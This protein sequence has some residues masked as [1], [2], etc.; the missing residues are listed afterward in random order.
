MDRGLFYQ[1]GPLSPARFE[2]LAK[3]VALA[4]GLGLDAVWCLPMTDADGGFRGSAPEIWLAGLAGVTKSIRLGWG[5]P[6]VWPPAVAPVREAEQA[7]TL[8]VACGGRLDVAV[9]PEVADRARSEPDAD[10]DAPPEPPASMEDFDEGI[11]MWVE[12]WAPAT[13]SWT[14]KRLS[15]PAIDV[16]PKPVQRP[17]PPLWLVG[18]SA[19]HADR[20]GRAGL[21]FLDVSGGGY[22]IWCAHRECYVAARGEA[23]PE[24]LVCVSVYAVAADPPEDFRA[25][26]GGDESVRDWLEELEAIGIDQVVLRAGPLDGGHAEACRRIQ[27]LANN[28]SRGQGARRR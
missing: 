15:V 19:D 26:A 27:W 25:D 11:R 28:G 16:V 6:G 7:A 13:F 17:H 23:N 5:V 4:E 8:D 14:S 1:V 21:G 12:M 20:A 24:D 2:E 22:E 3:E 18:W 10:A 9:L